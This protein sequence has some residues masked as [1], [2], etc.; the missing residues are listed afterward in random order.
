M[1]EPV[2]HADIEDVLSSIRRLVSDG[3]HA[4]PAA[5]AG[6]QAPEPEPAPKAAERLVLTPA[7]RV[8]GTAAGSSAAAAEPEDADPADPVPFSS[9][10]GG[11]AAGAPDPAGGDGSAAEQAAAPAV[12]LHAPHLDAF[13]FTSRLSSAA[14]EAAADEPP[15]DPEP[16]TALQEAGSASPEAAADHDAPWREPGST[17]FAAARKPSAQEAAEAPAIEQEP[18]KPAVPEESAAEAEDAPE[19][20]SPPK[21]PGISAVV[22]K[23]AEL[24]ARVARARDQWEPDGQS[25]DP[26]AGTNIQ[27]LEWEDHQDEPDTEA[28]AEA[29]IHAHAADPGD[30]GSDAAAVAEDAETG[31][32]P[33]ALA[34]EDTYLDEDSLRELVA[35]IVREELQGA[36]GERITRNVRKLVRREILRALASQDLI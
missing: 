19:T 29:A 36:L 4:G 34:G 23:I 26:Y 18:I 31:A 16:G 1:T 28:E 33:E 8:Q 5:T 10:R 20:S 2:K 14:D 27:T 24:E 6:A 35:A 11:S 25:S 21:R 22:R 12:D 17:L 32:E 15:R 13:E 30:A 9:A 3:A 7:L